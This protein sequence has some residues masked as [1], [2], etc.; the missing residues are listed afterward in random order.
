MYGYWNATELVTYPL[1]DNRC[2]DDGKIGDKMV[3]A[4]SKETL[5]TLFEGAKAFQANDTSDVDYDT[6]RMD[7]EKKV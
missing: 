4:S 1:L 6:W 2:P 5:K 7:L 3:Y